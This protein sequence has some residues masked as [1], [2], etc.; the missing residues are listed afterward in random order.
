MARLRLRHIGYVLQTGG[1]MCLTSLFA[2]VAALVD[3]LLTALRLRG[4]ID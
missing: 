2:I 3:E 4:M 1:L